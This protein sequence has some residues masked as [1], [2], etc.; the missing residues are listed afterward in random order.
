MVLL[1]WT[2]LGVLVLRHVWRRERALDDRTSR[3]DA[4]RERLA[5]RMPRAVSSI[6]VSPRTVAAVLMVMVV[7]AVATVWSMLD[8]QGRY[9]LPTV[10]MA[11]GTGLFLV[12][13]DDL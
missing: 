7:V 8:T 13:W 6:E 2:F 4:A 5:A 1:G 9:Y 12:F 3:L 10:G 11:A